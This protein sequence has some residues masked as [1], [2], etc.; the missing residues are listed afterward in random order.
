MFLSQPTMLTLLFPLLGV[1]STAVILGNRPIRS[2]KS[3]YQ[4][5]TLVSCVVFFSAFGFFSYL[6]GLISYTTAAFLQVSYLMKDSTQFLFRNF[7][8][9]QSQKN[10]FHIRSVWPLK[11]CLQESNSQGSSFR[12]FGRPK[13]NLGIWIHQFKLQNRVRP[14]C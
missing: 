8:L 11:L 12:C 3:L 7:Y 1:I 2:R 10:I 6:Y 5:L 4:L 13:F 14:I 9:E